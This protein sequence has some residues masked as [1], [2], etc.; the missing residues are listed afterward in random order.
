MLAF[1]ERVRLWDQALTTVRA[2]LRARGLAEVTT[3]LRREEVALEPWIE[4]VASGT[5]WLVTSPEL[6]LKLLV[7]RGAGPI[8]QL[9]HVWRAGERGLWHR[10]EFRLVEWYRPGAAI[11][12]LQD[13]VESL[14]AALIEAL[15]PWAPT[16]VA[17]PRWRSEAWLD[18]FA[19]TTGVALDGDESPEVLA[20]AVRGTAI[21]SWPPPPAG[22]DEMR[23]LWSWSAL[24]SA[25]SDACLDPWLAERAAAGEAVHLVEFPPALAALSRCDRDGAGRGV[26]RRFESHAFGRE[27]CNGY[28]ELRDAAEQRRRFAA[29]A[30]MREAAGQPAIGLPEG[31]LAALRDPGLPECVGA[32]LGLERLVACAVGAARLDEVS[33]EP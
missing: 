10:P 13:D 22:D 15:S 4:P 30:A 20:A 23:G 17:P 1:G 32:A 14:M 9:A 25:W 33:L 24:F 3:D 12:A 31:F 16:R 29:V 11:T 2:H 5:A 7:M 26:A 19:A 6:A 28:D 18:L 21:S 27:L 8:F